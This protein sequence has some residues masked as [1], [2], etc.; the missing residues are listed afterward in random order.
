MKDFYDIY[1]LLNTYDFDRKTLREAI[2]ETFEN[3]STSF[4]KISAFEDG[5]VSDPYKKGIWSSFIKAKKVTLN[6]ELDLIIDVIKKFLKPVLDDKINDISFQWN[7]VNLIW[8]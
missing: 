6:V 1:V 8:E 5:F 2:I 4:N 7:H 3:R